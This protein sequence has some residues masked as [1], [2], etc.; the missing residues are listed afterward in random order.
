MNK[1]QI[2]VSNRAKLQIAEIYNYI[3]NDSPTNAK[4]VRAKI[5]EHIGLLTNMPEKYP[6]EW[7]LDQKQGE[8][9]FI[10]IYSYK[11]IYEITASHIIVLQIFHTSQNP[12]KID[13]L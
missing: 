10:P 9:R 1:R 4:K 13:K 7:Y 2:I 5:I 3:K 12:D 6:R 11:I 8:F